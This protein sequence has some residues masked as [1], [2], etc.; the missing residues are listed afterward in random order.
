M[1][2]LVLQ[3]VMRHAQNAVKSVVKTPQSFVLAGWSC[4]GAR[5]RLVASHSSLDSG[6][7]KLENNVIEKTEV[8][9]SSDWSNTEIRHGFTGSNVGT[10]HGDQMSEWSSTEIRHGFTDSSVSNYHVNQG[11]Y[12]VA[13]VH[14]PHEQQSDDDDDDDD[15]GLPLSRSNHFP[16]LTEEY[17]LQHL[18]HEL[19][20][21]RETSITEREEEEEVAKKLTQEEE[22]EVAAKT[23]KVGSDCIVTDSRTQGRE[24]NRFFPPG[25]IIHLLSIETD[26]NIIEGTNTSVCE[27]RSVRAGLFIT[28]RALYGNVHLSRTMINDHYM[29][30]YRRMM[31][32]VVKDIEQNAS[33]G[34]HN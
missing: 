19:D 12:S 18:E 23:A 17:L 15:E 1:F 24:L 27:G 32:S 25:R 9:T 33:L 7:E 29:P 26:V 6:F 10:Y 14:D 13:R 30:N 28:D 5:R 20:R 4:M 34:V 11:S 16:E 21:Q 8:L 2:L 3:V 31:E 22:E